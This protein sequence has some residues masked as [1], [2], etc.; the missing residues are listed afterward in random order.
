MVRKV[1]AAMGDSRRLGNK[2]KGLSNLLLAEI[3][4]YVWP[5]IEQE[6]EL[7]EKEK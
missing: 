3:E 1:I 4:E 6:I 2:L 7:L 5:V